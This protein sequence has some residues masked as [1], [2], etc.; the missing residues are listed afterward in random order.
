METM[1]GWRK[2]AA[3]GLIF[4]LCSIVTVRVVWVCGVMDIP[5]GVQNILI[6]VTSAFFVLNVVG[7]HTGSSP[8]LDL[9]RK[10]K[11]PDAPA[12]KAP[13]EKP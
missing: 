10:A 1:I 13:E 12:E 5:Q 8:A 11:A 9:K 2:L 3:W 6:W 4:S 7:E